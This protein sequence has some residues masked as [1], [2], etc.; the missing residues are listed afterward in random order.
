MQF[1]GA[2]IKEQGISFAI[3]VVKPTLLS[4]TQREETR[5]SFSKYFPGVPIVLMVQD[6]RGTPTYHGRQDIVKFLANINPS[7][8]PFKRYTAN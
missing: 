1:D 3:V 7:R 2:L 8:I 5:M 6:G 4:S